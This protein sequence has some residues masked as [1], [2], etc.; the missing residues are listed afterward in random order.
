MTHVFTCDGGSGGKQTEHLPVGPSVLQIGRPMVLNRQWFYSLKVDS[1]V[2]RCQ[3]GQ[4]GLLVGRKKTC[5]T[6]I[7]EGRAEKKERKQERKKERK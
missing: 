2:F 4:R 7:K 5:P 3:R 1:S 6:L